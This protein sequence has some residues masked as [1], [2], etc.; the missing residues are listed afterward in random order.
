MSMTTWIQVDDRWRK[1]VIWGSASAITS[2]IERLDSSLPTEW[3]R[4][5]KAE[6]NY[7][8]RG[9]EFPDAFCYVRHV[10]QSEVW[11]W[12]NQPSP[13]RLVGGNVIPA[14][15]LREYHKHAAETILQFRAQVL[16]PAAATTGAHIEDSPIGPLTQ[17]S[18]AVMEFLW[19]FVDITPRTIPL[20]QSSLPKWRAFVIAARTTN[21]T[22]DPTELATWFEAKGWS[23]ADAR[24]LADKFFEDAWLLS[25]Y[26]EA[27]QP[28]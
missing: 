2:L 12:L 11:L 25:A 7:Q 1:T 26:D 17:A 23:Q 24:A 6:A 3:T 22:F 5:R 13:T 4:N 15:S 27:R 18:P 14:T 19:Q 28:A 16:E 20:T 8:L 10:E 9:G 21:A